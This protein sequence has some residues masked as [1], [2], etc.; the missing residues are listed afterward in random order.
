MFN[1]YFG[2]S[3]R[4][5]TRD[6]AISVGAL[7]LAFFI[8][9]SVNNRGSLTPYSALE[10]LLEALVG[11]VTAFLLHELSHRHLARNYGGTAYFRMWPFGIILALITSV[12][13]FIFAAPGAVNISGIYNREQIG[14]IAIAGPMTNMLMGF[15]FLG[16]A[17]I[18][19]PGSILQDVTYFSAIINFWFSLFNMIPF[20]PLDGS[21]VIAWNISYYGIFVAVALVM[22]VYLF[23]I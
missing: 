7:T 2:S 13:G 14:K 9:N 11:M 16:I 3:S 4:A 8:Y 15:L 10:Y 21:K 6:I 17:I 5:E 22:N 19:A 23:T 20:P 12:I 18:S 1:G